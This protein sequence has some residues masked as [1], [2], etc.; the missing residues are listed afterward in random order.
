MYGT[1]AKKFHVY[2]IILF[3]RVHWNDLLGFPSSCAYPKSRQYSATLTTSEA[4]AEKHKSFLWCSL[5]DST[6][7]VVR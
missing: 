5:V 4:F 2:T 7:Q 6:L 1:V 3:H